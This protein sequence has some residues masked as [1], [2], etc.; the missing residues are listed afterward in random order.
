VKVLTRP[1]GGK[2]ERPYD[3]SLWEAREGQPQS[4]Q[5]P[6]DAAAYGLEPLSYL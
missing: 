6:V 1:G 4:V 2:L 3:V 5:A